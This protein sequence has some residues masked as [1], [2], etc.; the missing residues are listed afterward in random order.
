MNM[1]SK[2]TVKCGIANCPKKDEV[3]TY[4][5]M[6]DN[7]VHECVVKKID[8]PNDCG[9]KITGHQISKDIHLDSCAK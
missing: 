1:L 9:E 8:C 6:C 2:L 3:M 7:H 5:S 4:Q